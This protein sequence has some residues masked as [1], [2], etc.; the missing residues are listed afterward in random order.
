MSLME[1]K[2]ISI[3]WNPYYWYCRSFPSCK[4]GEAIN[5]HLCVKAHFGP[6]SHLA[7][8]KSSPK[9]NLHKGHFSQCQFLNTPTR[10]SS[11]SNKRIFFWFPVLKNICKKTPIVNCGKGYWLHSHFTQLLGTRQSVGMR[12]RTTVIIVRSSF[13]VWAPGSYGRAAILWFRQNLDVTNP[14]PPPPR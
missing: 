6:D 2:W 8:N 10:F 1:K 12:Q 13:L 5:W 11:W 9:K 14:L 3:F 4:M 7:G